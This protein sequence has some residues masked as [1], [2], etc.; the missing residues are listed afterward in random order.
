MG[1][2]GGCVNPPILSSLL[3]Q[4]HLFGLREARSRLSAGHAAAHRDVLQTHPL[5]GPSKYRHG[6]EHFLKNSADR[7]LVE[8][9]R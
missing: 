7:W 5:G 3:H 1:T 6:S 8:R 4:A 2:V 9:L